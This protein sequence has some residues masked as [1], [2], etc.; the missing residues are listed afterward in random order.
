MQ[1]ESA[2]MEAVAREMEAAS[3]PME[4]IGKEMEAL[5]TQLERQANIAD[6]QMR[7]LIDEAVRQGL[8]QP[9]PVRR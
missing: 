7:T 9:A 1:G 3:K 5:G 8:A 2:K 4:A 6:A